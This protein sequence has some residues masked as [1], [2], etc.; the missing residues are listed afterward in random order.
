MGKLAQRVLFFK[1]VRSL[2]EICMSAVVW[3][4]HIYQQQKRWPRLS[5][6]AIIALIPPMSG[7][8][9]PVFSGARSTSYDLAWMRMA[10]LERV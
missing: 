8:P 9:E 4:V 10:L 5:C 7:E 6:M 3:S 1:R 2:H